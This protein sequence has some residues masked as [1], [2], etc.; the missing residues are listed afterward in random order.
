MKVPVLAVA[1]MATVLALALGVHLQSLVHINHD[2]G[3]IAHSAGWLLDGK[4]F[5]TDIVDPNPPMAW[6][7]MLPAELV[8]RAGLVPE[9]VAIKAWSWLLTALGVALAW[10][11]LWPMARTL[12]RIEVAGMLVATAAVAAILPIGNFGQRDVIAFILILPYLFLL[13]RRLHGDVP[14]PAASLAWLA[15]LGAGI[16]FCLKPFLLAVP[17]LAEVL[18]LL[19]TRNF[20]VWLRGEILAI[21]AVVLAYALAVLWLAPDYLDFALPMIAS[22]YWAYDDSGYLILSRFK[23]AAWPAAYAFGIGLVTWSFTRAHAVLFA[24]VGG[25]AASYWLQRKGFPYHAYPLLGASC[26]L[27]VYSAIHGA[28][29]VLE[30]R[31]IPRQYLRYALAAL[32]V[33]VA[34]PALREPFEDAAAWYRNFDTEHGE[35]GMRRQALIDRLRALGIGPDDYVYALT[36]HPHPGFPTVNY[37]GTRWSGRSVTQ[38]VMPAEVRK[39]EVTDPAILREIERASSLQVRQVVED[40][41]AHPPRIVMV[42]ARQRR[43]G[44]AYRPFDDI[45]FYSRDPGFAALW[46]CYVEIGTMD[47]IRLFQRRDDCA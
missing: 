37:L 36:T 45:A 42:E 7:L 40:L 24:A 46:R 5:G 41:A 26:I 12:G 22:V 9:V 34:L 31:L 38:F 17:V 27:L 15:G 19:L 13:I 30:A 35:N 10:A 23:D 43:L 25:F 16:G 39:A 20:L 14:V 1:G 47:Q 28:R 44:L 3:W 29:R 33:L 11:A 8:A 6:F 32:L 4:R 21:A 18:H 2:L